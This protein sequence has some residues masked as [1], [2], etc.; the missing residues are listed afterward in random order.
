MEKDEEELRIV[1][2]DLGSGQLKVAA[3]NDSVKLRTFPPLIATKNC[4]EDLSEKLELFGDEISD[5]CENLR[6]KYAIKRGMVTNWDLMERI[7]YYTFYSKLEIDPSDTLLLL[8][9]TILN[10]KKNRE[11]LCKMIFEVFDFAGF[12]L[13]L[14]CVLPFFIY[15]WDTGLV[16]DSGHG[17]TTIVPVYQNFLIPHAAVS[18]SLAGEDITDFLSTLLI[19]KGYNFTTSSGSL[20]V[21]KIKQEL[22][23]VSSNYERDIKTVKPE[24]EEFVLTNGRKIT[25]GKAMFQA[26]ELIFQPVL[27]KRDIPPLHLLLFR[28]ILNCDI[29]VR[30][31][32]FQNI[33]LVG[34]NTL[35]SGFQ[36]RLQNELQKLAPKKVSVKVVAP[37]DRKESICKSA[38]YVAAQPFLEQY[39]VLK[40]E[41]EYFGPSVIN[42]KK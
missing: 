27:D 6:L 31:D 26:P 2:V 39:W 40:E 15:H 32:L 41:Y 33:L 21:E 38:A 16:V 4:K 20:I 24:G 5:Q 42:K 19:K 23:F 30:K 36:K 29:D 11:R 9:E 12:F 13:T 3:D 18:V 7:F 25:L 37:E 28:S 35:F 14:D 22:C 10:P 17:V 34:G 1:V 8:T